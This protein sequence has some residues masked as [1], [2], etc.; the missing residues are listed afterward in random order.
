MNKSIKFKNGIYL[1]SS[2][3]T[4]N[5]KQLSNMLDVKNLNLSLV[6]QSYYSIPYSQYTQG[7][8]LL[9]HITYICF[10]LHV[11][12]V[13]SSDTKIFSVPKAL[14]QP[15]WQFKCWET[16]N[17]NSTPLVIRIDGNG[18]MYARNGVK[19]MNYFVQI[20]YINK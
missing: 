2:G 7:S 13:P 20:N 17:D 3:V 15:H 16:A 12:N 19:G 4:H 9:D 18:D 1:D 10:F 11:N 6:N 8:Q 5:Q 14:S